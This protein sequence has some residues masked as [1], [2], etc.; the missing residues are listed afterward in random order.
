VPSLVDA[1]GENIRRVGIVDNIWSYSIPDD[2]PEPDIAVLSQS[3]IISASPRNFHK[4]VGKKDI[5]SVIYK[6]EDNEIQVIRG[7]SHT[8]PMTDSYASHLINAIAALI[9]GSQSATQQPGQQT[10][11]PKV[12]SLLQ[13]RR[14]LAAR[15][16]RLAG[17]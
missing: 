6:F 15:R 9:P 7:K 5:R 1:G 11:E 4:A 16:G 13:A 12:A 3:L 10:P 2:A 17:R 8:R 14:S